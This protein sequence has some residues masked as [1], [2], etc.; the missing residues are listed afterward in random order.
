MTAKQGQEDEIM[1]YLAMLADQSSENVSPSRLDFMLE[2]LTELGHHDQVCAALD[3]LLETSRRFPTVGEVKTLLGLA[4]ASPENKGREVAERIFGAITKGWGS[5][6][7]PEVHK[8][9][10]E[11]VGPIGVE[12]VRMAG[13]WPRL[14]EIKQEDATTHKAQWREF[15]AIIARKGGLGDAPQFSELPL[16]EVGDAVAALAAR[17]SV[18]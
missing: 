17:C 6:L 7:R 4:P 12:V 1:K 11:F 8:Q 18:P 14:S 9:R 13:G 5:S 10:D 2:K 3:A 16:G 15:A